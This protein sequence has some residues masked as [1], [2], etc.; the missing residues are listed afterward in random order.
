MQIS[1]EATTFI[2]TQVEQNSQIIIVAF[3]AP[4]RGCC[5]IVM[6]PSIFIT[7]QEEFYRELN[8]KNSEWKIS[9]FEIKNILDL[10]IPLFWHT[11]IKNSWETAEIDLT[12]DSNLILF[13]H[14]NID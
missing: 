12:S 4:T 6:K 5:Y 13:L 3:E 9:D 2:N 10:K 1:S 7:T 14:N 11:S 8:K